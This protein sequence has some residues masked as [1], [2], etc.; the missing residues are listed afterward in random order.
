[1]LF[2][3]VDVLS[4]CIL[5]ALCYLQKVASHAMHI[6]LNC[7][8]QL[9]RHRLILVISCVASARGRGQAEYIVAQ[10][11]IIISMQFVLRA[12]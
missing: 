5:A 10:L 6:S 1:M 9:T 8:L 11:V 7:Y 12:W 2:D 4:R 3:A